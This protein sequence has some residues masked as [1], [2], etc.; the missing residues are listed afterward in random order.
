MQAEALGETSGRFA[1]LVAS[2]RFRERMALY[3]IDE[4]HNI[5]RWGRSHH[6]V[7]PFKPAWARLGNERTQLFKN[8]RTL[9]LTATAPPPMIPIIIESLK[10]HPDRCKVIQRRLNRANICYAARP[11]I[12]SIQNLAN[13][14]FIVPT[15][16]CNLPST[17]ILPQ[18]PS[19]TYTSPH[20]AHSCIP[21]RLL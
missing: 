3:A 15:P 9:A 16:D 4:A 2:S 14:D 8:P 1:E 5:D 7:P 10:L 19:F 12:G 20:R 6:G 11:L 18:Q 17:P 13:Y 21:W